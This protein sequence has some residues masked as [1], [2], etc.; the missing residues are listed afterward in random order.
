MTVD[1]SWNLD[2]LVEA[3]KQHQRRARGLREQTLRGYESHVRLFVRAALGDDPIDPTRLGPSDVIEFITLMAGRVSPASIKTVRT[4]LRSFFRFLRVEGICDESLEKSL[5]TV[6]R[7]RFSTLP[8]CLSDQQLD[9]V[10]ASLDTSTP[11]GYRDRAIVL[12][13]STLGLRPREVSELRLDD[14]DWRRGTIHLRER[15]TR[16]GAVVWSCP[17]ACRRC[18]GTARP[19][20]SCS[21]WRSGCAHAASHGS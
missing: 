8:R 14:I 16:D 1:N 17:G 2:A 12:C 21:R 3:Y 20:A 19:P 11:C 7:W 6:A 15:K 5:P 13:L 18:A 10:L 4:A 9:R